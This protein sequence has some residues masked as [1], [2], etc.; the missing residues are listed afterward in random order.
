MSEIT[1][2]QSSDIESDYDFLSSIEPHHSDL[3]RY[4]RMIAG[5]PWDGDDLLQETLIKAF[6]SAN[7]LRK[8]PAPKAYLFRIA[9]NAWIDHCRKN[10]I[11]LDTYYEEKLPDPN[12]TLQFEVREAI[13]TLV[14]QLPPKQVAVVLLIDI[15]GFTA[16]A[17]ASMIDTTEGA[18]KAALHRARRKLKALK[19]RSDPSS[20]CASE[21]VEVFLEAFH[22]RDPLAVTQA[23]HSLKTHGVEVQR[24]S[25]GKVLSFQFK[26][27]DGNVF[28]VTAVPD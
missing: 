20:K 24:V 17:A 18:V 21:L 7:Q 9:T 27:P 16:N 19:E 26:D 8:H 22:K 28:T 13:E 25:Q 5:T 15:F 2:N 1:F 23:Y 12:E 6:K 14:H 4:C 3:T 10:K 11:R